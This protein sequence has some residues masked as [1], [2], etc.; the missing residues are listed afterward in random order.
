MITV[1]YARLGDSSLSSLLCEAKERFPH[2]DCAEYIDALAEKSN[3]DSARESLAALV[4]LGR[5]A[6]WMG[7]ETDELVL[8]RSQN[9]KPFFRGG[10]AEFSLTHSKGY[11]AAALSD[12]GEVGIDLEA[13]EY[14]TD[15]ARRLAE[16]YFC[17]REKEAFLRTLKDFL[18]IWTKKEACVKLLG[19]TLSEQISR[20]DAEDVAYRYFEI[21]GHPL[22]LCTYYSA[23]NVTFGEEKL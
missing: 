5:A 1:L 20:G 21:D 3:R 14:D 19:I 9:G 2:P 4:L 13:S 16:R 23:E 7:M 17:D 6:E 12:E 22:T 18:R 15:K 10:E 11:V 8:L